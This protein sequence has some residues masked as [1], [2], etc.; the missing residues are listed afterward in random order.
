MNGG[1]KAL[2]T[3]RYLAVVLAMGILLLPIYWIFLNSIKTNAQAA[4]V[5]PLWFFEPD[6]SHYIT[7]FT[8]AKFDLREAMFN[9]LVVSVGATALALAL[10]FTT[11]YSLSRY[12]TGGRSFALWILSF[13][14]LPPVVFVIPMYILFVKYGLV[15]TQLGLILL[16][17]IFNIPITVWILRSFIDDIPK[18]FEEAAIVDGCTPTQAML[19]IVFPL[20]TPG[21]VASAIVCFIFSFNEFIFAYIFTQSNAVTMPAM[22]AIF[23]GRYTYEW[24][25]LSASIMVMTIPMVIF[26]FLVQRWLVRG[27]TMGAIKG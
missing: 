1:K 3:L 24:A 27:L 22:A 7:I 12:K 25:D 6:L 16:Y 20:S 13:R 21:L 17:L 5:P 15:D 9:S 11:A 18:D 23:I 10:S 2:L 26:S 8:S 4:S 19:K 14:M